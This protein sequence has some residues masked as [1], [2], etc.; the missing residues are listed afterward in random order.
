MP[1]AIMMV[2]FFV[3]LSFAARTAAQ[4]ST[5]DL[6]KDI[7][8]PAGGLVAE[9]SPVGSA[10]GITAQAAGATAY[11]LTD[12]V[13][14]LFA[15]DTQ[16]GVVSVAT[17]M[18]DY[19][20]FF[21]HTIIVE[22]S[23]ATGSQTAPFTIQITDVPEPLRAVT[24]IDLSPNNI[25]HSAK[26]GDAV[27]ITARAIDPDQGSSVAYSLSENADGLFAIGEHD[28]IITLA[29]DDYEPDRDYPI[30][31]TAISSDDL[32]TSRA[33]QFTVRQD[34]P[35]RIVLAPAASTLREGESQ[36]I[37]FSFVET[38][39]EVKD[40]GA[41]AYHNCVI[42]TGNEAVCWGSDLDFLGAR[43]GQ[44]MP[45]SDRKFIAISSGAYHSCA[46]A[47]GNDAVCWGSNEN[48]LSERTV[49]QSMPPSGRKFI[50]ISAG[51]EHTCGI[52][53]DNDAVCWGGNLD[54]LG[55]RVGQSMPPSGRKFIAISAGFSHTCG[56][57]LDNDAVCW[58]S[59][60]NVLSERTVG[61]S[62][63]PSGRKF[64]AVS[65]GGEH[66]CG[67]T[68]DND[69]VCWGGNEDAI[70][71]RTVGRSMPPS[72]RKFIA[73]SA[74]GRHTCGI[75]PDN[76]AVCWGRDTQ[77]QRS[78]PSG[79]KFIAISAGSSHSCGITLDSGAVCWGDDADG[80]RTP[81]Q[82]L[83]TAADPITITA[84]VSD[85]DRRQLSLSGDGQAIIPAGETQ[86][87]LT[88]TVIDDNISEPETVYAIAL[89]AT[90]PH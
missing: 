24:D 40:I 28:G 23:S 50:A 22:A 43:V 21:F 77:K 30:E 84:T 46:I 48:A 51:G 7:D 2:T 17:D 41:G 8:G 38:G 88:V 4:T 33:A 42:T 63:P 74:G 82:P 62:M 60:K 79:R 55:A 64:I 32:S 11:T 70:S 56:I 85:A 86:V 66:T 72:D 36:D 1:L 68:L 25:S 35:I 76:D 52:T 27:G 69:A 34:E 75:T 10:V 54:F 12:S 61:Q 89:S 87:I 6:L 80:Q 65:A 13:D 57:T 83:L 59:N 49:G 44:S 47:I 71:G 73:V 81:P 58:G 29:S 3:L 78:P 9:N 45:P 16:T 15:I 26:R 20:A 67:I 39:L 90:R 53:L 31:V 14:G 18:L 19:E 5:A 37:S